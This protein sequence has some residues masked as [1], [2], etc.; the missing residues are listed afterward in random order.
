MEDLL[1]VGRIV[2]GKLRLDPTR[3]DVVAVVKQAV[4]MTMPAIDLRGHSLELLT[5]DTPIFADLDVPR[6]KQVVSNLLNNGAKFM[7]DGGRIEVRVGAEHG[8][9]S[10]R[11]R[12]YGVGI[13][14]DMIH[15]VFERFV[16]AP[17]EAKVTEGLGVGLSIVK[18][19]VELHGG[20]V[21]ARSDG[22]GL[23]SEFTVVVPD[24]GGH[25]GAGVDVEPSTHARVSP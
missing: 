17:T 22:P 13:P 10:I 3:A 23:G 5:P 21:V 6:M 19:I 1:D 25:T 7:P 9:A 16:Q 2:T 8:L 12:D 18:T 15:R 14:P 24:R 20:T 11:V 4:E